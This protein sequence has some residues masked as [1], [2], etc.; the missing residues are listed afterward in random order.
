MFFKTCQV[1]PDQ[2]AIACANLT[3]LQTRVTMW[4]SLLGSSLPSLC[5]KPSL[6]S[7]NIERSIEKIKMPLIW[8]IMAF[9]FDADV[10]IVENC[11]SS[12]QDFVADAIWNITAVSFSIRQVAQWKY[13]V[14]MNKYEVAWFSL[15]AQIVLTGSNIG[16]LKE[17]INQSGKIVS[18]WNVLFGVVFRCETLLFKLFGIELV[19]LHFS[20]QSR[21]PD[22]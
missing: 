7:R 12:M 20:P 15:F 14:I 2:V 10:M 13:L 22:V 19:T 9:G 5:D 16:S 11:P 17:E 8:E 6:L 4:E 18:W 21:T 3:G 1:F